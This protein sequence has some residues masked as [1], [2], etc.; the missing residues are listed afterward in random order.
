MKKRKFFHDYFSISLDE[1]T[2]QNYIILYEVEGKNIK[3][4]NWIPYPKIYLPP[5][6]F[7]L[8]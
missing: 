2:Q 7:I 8:N 1:E 3:R 6:P 5:Y 4:V